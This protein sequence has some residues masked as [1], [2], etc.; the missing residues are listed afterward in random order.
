MKHI[1][2]KIINDISHSPLKQRAVAFALLLKE[3][4]ENSSVVPRFTIYKVRKL[5]GCSYKT[6]K[7]YLAVLEK[8]GLSEVRNGNLYIKRMVSSAKHRN[9]DI[10]QFTFDKTK[11]LFEQI[12]EL[13]LLLIQANKD[14]IKRLLQLR[15]DPPRDV[16]FKALRKLCKKCCPDPNADYKEFGLSYKAISRKVGCCVRTAVKVVKCAVERGWCIKD[17][18]CKR[19]RMDGVWFMPVPGFT[20]TTRNYGYII[21]PNTYVLSGEWQSALSGGGRY[22]IMIR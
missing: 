15:K 19:K 13:L 9:I 11:E 5:T 16:D 4:T 7:K 10:S 18:H 20:F 22:G 2:R 21:R 17:K 14:F 8:M 3:K 1:R 12:R 6:I